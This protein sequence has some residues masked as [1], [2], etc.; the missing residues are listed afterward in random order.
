[1]VFDDAEA[2]GIATVSKAVNNNDNNFYNLQ[3][4]RISQP[5]KGIFIKGNKKVVKK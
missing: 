4:Q 3:G 5:S 2:T 1:M